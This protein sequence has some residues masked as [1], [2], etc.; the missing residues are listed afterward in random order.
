MS[1]AG[2]TP[3]QLYFSTT[4]AAV[5]VNT[6]LANGELAINITD[7]K[8]YFKN[9]AGVVKLLASNATSAP[10]LSFSAGTTGF[11]PSSATSGA[12][13]LAGTLATT[14][15]GTG[16]TSF[17]S[18]GVVYASSSSALATGSALTFDG[19]TLANINTGGTGFSTQDAA[20]NFSI[21]RLG[22]DVANGYAFFQSGKS[23][24][25]TTLPFAWRRDSSELMRLTSTGLGIGNN[26]PAYKLDVAGAIQA[27][28]T[29]YSSSTSPTV[30]LNNSTASTGRIFAL[31]SYDAGGFQIVDATAGG[32]TRYEVTGA[33]VTNIYGPVTISNVNAT[34]E[35]T[36]TGNDFTNVFSQTTS[37]FQFG[38]SGT[39]YLAF[40]ANNV[41]YLRIANGGAFGLSG[42]NYGL[43]GQVL[44]SG[45]SGAAPTWTTVGGG[46]G[47]PATPTVS[48]TVYGTTSGSSNVGIG[49]AAL[50]S[51]TSG[52]GN[53]AIGYNA[54]DDITSGTQNTIV[55]YGAYGGVSTASYNSAFGYQA[56]AINTSGSQNAAFGWLALQKNTTGGGNV[57][58]GAYSMHENAS[59][60]GNTAIGFEALG[61]VTNSTNDVAIGYQALSQANPA[62]SGYSGANVAIGYRAFYSLGTVASN[63]SGGCTAVGYAAGYSTTSAG[64]SALD[65]FIGSY[66]GYYNVSGYGC[67]FVGAQ[68]GYGQTS[69]NSNTIVGD[70]AGRQTSGA[71]GNLCTFVGASAGSANSGN[72]NTFVGAAAG[73]SNGGATAN[74]YFGT[75]AGQSN[76]GSSNVAI[77]QAAMYSATS[78]A[79][80][81]AIGSEALYSLTTSTGYH[82]AVGYQS[83]RSATDNSNSA[84]GYRSGYG[85][86]TGHNNTLLGI[87][88]G[89]GS[90]ILTGGAMNVVIGSGAYTNTAGAYGE[91]VIGAGCNGLGNDRVSIGKLNSRIWAQYDSSGSWTY[92]SDVRL[93]KDIED[94]SL[95][96]SF[97]NKLRPV[98]YRWKATNE[99]ELDNPQYNEVNNKNTTV[100]MHGLIAQEVKAALD[101]EGVSTFAG[102]AIEPNGIQSV[103]REM[104]IT[105]LI[106]AV[107]ELTAQ[108]EQ[109]KADF[110]AYKT[111]HP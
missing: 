23:G 63:G 36:F 18:G 84:L 90:V 109:L 95:G 103:S 77:G 4:A 58:L 70:R 76:T 44:T 53:T 61:T 39:G 27:T 68:A 105:P 102:W 60:T 80:N 50:V 101:E 48:G 3:I 9:A 13:T 6:N 26:N 21:M 5:P 51:I 19:T 74:A 73:A 29:G 42:A 62:V 14:N 34:N 78:A 64:N 30:F 52:T 86:T 45:G 16:L 75:Y 108:I 88:S 15:G 12:V 33:G 85:V 59:G 110:E 1:Q 46:G 56:L 100:V 41:E 8:L 54:G 28:G 47:S 99:L 25:G 107:Q 72:D 96:L 57:S 7:E 94:D 97:I 55:G 40:L 32:A 67:T 93:K 91:I 106:N 82:T 49:F 92:S 111:S 10:V 2:Y 38:T 11:T 66:A 37:G 43:S 87:N 31:N 71:G 104:F 24:T 69:G 98:K 81:V 65:T 83:L 79:V 22:T 17:T 20:S 89:Y 35:L